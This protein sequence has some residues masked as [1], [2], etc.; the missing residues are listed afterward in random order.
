MTAAGGQD[1][2]P[3]IAR[4]YDR[5]DDLLEAVRADGKARLRVYT[6]NEVAVVI[7]RGGRQPLELHTEAVARDGVP[8]YRRPG[9]GCSVVLDPG[10][11]IL[12]VALPL[13]GLGG[14]KSAFAGITRWLIV[15]LEQGCGLPGIQ[16]RGVSDLALAERKVGGS[17]VYRTRG[18]LSYAT[19][20]LVRPD[21]GLVERYLRHPP[22]EPQYRKGRL[23]RQFMGSL[24]Q[25]DPRL[26]PAALAGTL[27]PVLERSLPALLA[28]LKSWP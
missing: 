8:L 5:D 4:P 15:G 10:N 1:P 13:P 21:L 28:D 23:H 18:L 2:G 24:R 7:G 19:T 11:V 3:L 6:W 16:A 25:A 12:A 17:C 26:E 27:A 9:G 14:I 22:R 20:L